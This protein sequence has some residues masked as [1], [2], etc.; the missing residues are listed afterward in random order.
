M[1]RNLETFEVRPAT[2]T[3][4][5]LR[6][7]RASNPCT[8][9]KIAASSPTLLDVNCAAFQSIGRRTPISGTQHIIASSHPRQQCPQWLNECPVNMMFAFP[10]AFAMRAELAFALS[11]K[12]IEAGISLPLSSRV[13]LCLAISGML[14]LLSGKTICSPCNEFWRRWSVEGSCGSAQRR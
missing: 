12:I 13:P 9:R 7:P 1:Q 6:P 5:P 4:A 3:R 11:A 10:D 8:P 2:A 14:V